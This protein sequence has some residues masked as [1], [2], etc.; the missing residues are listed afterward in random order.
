MKKILYLLIMLSPVIVKADTLI[1]SLMCFEESDFNNSTHNHNPLMIDVKST[2]DNMGYA[3]AKYMSIDNGSVR[4][5]LT[6]F[7]A[8]GN[9]QKKENPNFVLFSTRQNT[10]D[11]GKDADFLGIDFTD[12]GTEDTPLYRAVEGRGHD[13]VSKKHTG[14]FCGL[15]K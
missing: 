3:V 2:D 1:I 8:N 11:L 9:T 7:K 10:E 14:Y 4:R 12:Y 5:G 6:Y 15:N 13:N